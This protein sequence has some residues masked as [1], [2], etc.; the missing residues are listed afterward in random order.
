M[1]PVGSADLEDIGRPGIAALVVIQIHADRHPV[2]I[3]AH[4]ATEVIA[5][6]PVGRGQLGCLHPVGSTALEDIGRTGI[7]SLV[8][9]HVRADRHPI[10]VNADREAEIIA[11]GAVGRLQLGRLHPVGAAALEDV[12]RTGG[13]ALVV[14]AVRADHDAV[15]ADGHRPAEVIGRGAVGR[16]QL[17]RVD[18]IRS[19][20]LEHISGPGRTPLVVVAVRADHHEMSVD[21]HTHSKVVVRCPIGGSQLDF[22]VDVVRFQRVPAPEVFLQVG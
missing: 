17:G 9:I 16:L 19:I 13:A 10:A 7:G 6:G 3:D 20:A 18:P 4:R 1:H 5:G 2:A 22:R 8:V 21:V 12:G 15:R 14:I 11:G